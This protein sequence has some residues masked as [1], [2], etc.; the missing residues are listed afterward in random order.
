[1][2]THYHL[3]KNIA[4]SNIKDLSYPY[5][6]TMCLTYWCNFKCKTCNIWQKKPK[7]EMT[8][9]DYENFF[10]KNN[11]FSWIDLTGGEI[12]LRK[13]IKE[14]ILMITKNCKNLF[15][16]HFPTNASMG[17]KVI[18]TVSE[19]LKDY[20]QNFVV[21][22]SLD[23]N[24][25]KHNEIRG[26]PGSY[27]KC[28][29]LYKKLKLIEKKHKKFRVYFGFTLSIFNINDFDDMFKQLKIELPDISYKDVHM[30]IFHNSDHYYG[31]SKIEN[32]GE[33]MIHE[34]NRFRALRGPP[35]NP[36]ELLEHSYLQHVE[37][38]IKT[39]KTPIVCE[40]LSSSCF[41]DSWGDVYPCIIYNKKVG[42]ILKGDLRDI[43]AKKEAREL[44]TQIK[45]KNCPNCWT[46]CE[47]YQ[48]IL[49]HSPRIFK[50]LQK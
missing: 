19:V 31:N 10:K 40:A 1:M 36:I 28:I 45:K 22:I 3:A 43:W 2:R 34:V 46:P 42:N 32:P 14:L 50:G 6:I 37:G 33:K 18:D 35:K 21:T 7:D 9:T 24:E 16:L 47:A 30:N 39:G 26:F 25:E 4:A 8:L 13:D 12:F 11:K 41:I 15:E 49:A 17:P 20:K 23:G 5:K 48:S 44:R 38:F 29:E 27:R